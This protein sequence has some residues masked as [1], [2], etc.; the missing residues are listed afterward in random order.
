MSYNAKYGSSDP[1]AAASSAGPPRDHSDEA[2]ETPMASCSLSFY[3][4]LSNAQEI[5]A[6]TFDIEPDDAWTYASDRILAQLASLR[7]RCELYAND[8][9]TVMEVRNTLRACLNVNETPAHT[10][11]T[12]VALFES[13]AVI[14]DA[15][16]VQWFV[17]CA[18][19]LLK[20][21]VGTRPQQVLEREE[22]LGLSRHKLRHRDMTRIKYLLHPPCVSG[23]HVVLFRRCL[24]LNDVEVMQLM[25]TFGKFTF[26][27]TALEK[28]YHPDLQTSMLTS[29]WRFGQ[30]GSKIRLKHH[31]NNVQGMLMAWIL[32]VCQTQLTQECR[33]PAGTFLE[34]QRTCA[35]W[36]SD[37][38]VQRVLAHARCCASRGLAHSEVVQP[39]ID[40]MHSHTAR[41][42]VCECTFAEYATE[43]CTLL[44]SF[45]MEF[46]GYGLQN[47]ATRFSTQK[48]STSKSKCYVFSRAMVVAIV[49]KDFECYRALCGLLNWLHDMPP[50]HYSMHDIRYASRF[51]DLGI[52]DHYGD[53]LVTLPLLAAVCTGDFDAVRCVLHNNMFDDVDWKSTA[54]P[55]AL[56]F[57]AY[58]GHTCMVQAFCNFQGYATA[59]NVAMAYAHASNAKAMLMTPAPATLDDVAPREREEVAHIWWRVFAALAR[60]GAIEILLASPAILLNLYA[61]HMKNL[62]SNDQVFLEFLQ[63]AAQSGCSQTCAFAV[64]H[65]LGVCN[66]EMYV[67]CI[68]PFATSNDMLVRFC[69]A[70]LKDNPRDMIDNIIMSAAFCY[71]DPII[72]IGHAMAL[73]IALDL[74]EKKVQLEKKEEERCG[75][76]FDT[77][78]VAE[79][80]LDRLSFVKHDECTGPASDCGLARMFTTLRSIVVTGQNFKFQVLRKCATN[81][82][83]PYA[84][85][86]VIGNV[87]SMKLVTNVL[88]DQESRMLG[89][90][91]NAQG[92][93]CKKNDRRAFQSSYSGALLLLYGKYGAAISSALPRM[94]DDDI[95]R[96]YRY[97]RRGTDI[98]DPVYWERARWIHDAFQDMR[99]VVQEEDIIGLTLAYCCS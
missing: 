45:R 68:V 79:S 5:Y 10:P 89:Y 14:P 35:V 91:N 83:C 16:L 78:F 47:Q 54:I 43:M 12:I 67:K 44:P 74:H 23:D 21:E 22:L 30:N 57:A 73:E 77:L 29:A 86:A 97:G 39:Y 75:P 17:G 63:A 49:E 56:N 25:L 28:S 80:A 13:A 90:F 46:T 58:T 1:S 82:S 61:F 42:G 72:K 3:H 99:T 32:A 18:C 96:V 59:G 94:N 85:Q 34:L 60:R 40:A 95:F 27:H 66:P 70:E 71:P 76:H 15:A 2:T 55:A 51:K 88:S 81:V 8:A 31:D 52:I 98:R 4:D 26:W 87:T 19:T 37:E 93:K 33:T 53:I 36:N 64:K 41:S 48:Y 92:K 7:T 20:N 11:P 69:P 38:N 65:T 50:R 9:S 84:M 24:Q 62:P 6:M